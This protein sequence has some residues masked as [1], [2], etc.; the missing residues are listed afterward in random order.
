MAWKL[1]KVSLICS[2]EWPT[3]N[4][5]WPPQGNFSLDTIKKVC[6]VINKPGLHGHPDQYPYILM[7]QTLVEDPP[8]WLRLYTH[9]APTDSP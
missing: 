9:E 3:F 2:V 5:G 7:W 6:N 1:R 4:V 8:S